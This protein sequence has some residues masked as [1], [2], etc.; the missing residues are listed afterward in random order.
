MPSFSYFLPIKFLPF[1]Q[2]RLQKTHD[3]KQSQGTW[4]NLFELRAARS[5]ISINESVEKKVGKFWPINLQIVV[6]IHELI[7]EAVV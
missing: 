3:E 4:S 6:I 1:L 7:T 5:V 2:A